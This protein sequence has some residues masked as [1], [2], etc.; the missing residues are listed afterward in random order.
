[1]YASD[2]VIKETVDEE[3]SWIIEVRLPTHQLERIF[4]TLKTQWQNFEI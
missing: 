1:L 4:S 3:G 2:A